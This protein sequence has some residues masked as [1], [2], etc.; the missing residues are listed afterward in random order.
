VQADLF[1]LHLTGIAGHET[2]TS[3]GWSQFAVVL[4]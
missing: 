2:R 3:Q 4:H 1:T